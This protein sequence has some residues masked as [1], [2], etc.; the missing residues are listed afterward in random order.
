PEP[1]LKISRKSA[2]MFRNAFMC[3]P[4]RPRAADRRFNIFRERVQINR[5][6]VLRTNVFRQVEKHRSAVYIFTMT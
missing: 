6:E 3:S 4:L 2:F 5:A 1:D